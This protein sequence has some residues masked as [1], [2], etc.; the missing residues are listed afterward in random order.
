MATTSDNIGNEETRSERILVSADDE[1]NNVD[2]CSPSED[3]T[4]TQHRRKHHRCISDDMT[5]AQAREARLR[6]CGAIVPV[7]LHAFIAIIVGSI[8]CFVFPLFIKWL[9]DLP[10]VVWIAI[11]IIVSVVV[12]LVLQWLD[13]HRK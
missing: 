8:V 11:A 6:R 2:D 10:Y 1:R 9:A 5:V 13:D 7:L 12:A 4:Q 3:G